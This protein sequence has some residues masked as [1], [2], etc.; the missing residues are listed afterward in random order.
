PHGVLAPVH[1]L[2]A[3]PKSLHAKWG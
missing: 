1:T 2:P 3:F